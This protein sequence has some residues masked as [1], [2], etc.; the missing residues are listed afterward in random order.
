MTDIIDIDFR[1][2]GTRNELRP[3]LFKEFLH[4]LRLEPA[5]ALTDAVFATVLQIE[6]LLREPYR[7]AQNIP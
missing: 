1:K 4:Y 6:D 5:V 7:P 2:R 3:N